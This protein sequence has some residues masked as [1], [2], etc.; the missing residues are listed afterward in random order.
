MRSMLC[1]N[2]CIQ[3]TLDFQSE[4]FCKTLFAMMCTREA[5]RL[6]EK[7][8]DFSPFNQFSCIEFKYLNNWKV[9]VLAASQRLAETTIFI[10][11]KSIC[12]H[13]VCT[14]L[15]PMQKSSIPLSI[16]QWRLSFRPPAYCLQQRSCE[17]TRHVMWPHPGQHLWVSSESAVPDKWVC[18]DEQLMEW[19]AKVMMLGEAPFCS[20]ISIWTNTTS[21]KCLI[22]SAKG[23]P[24]GTQIHHLV[25]ALPFLL[26]WVQKQ[27]VGSSSTGWKKEGI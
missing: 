24:G 17:M 9:L 6:S 21:C 18:G 23:H 13:A 27:L 20:L 12:Q 2:A 15:A 16:D 10:L 7:R 1:K 3:T 14:K 22:T 8:Y 5:V 26:A 25:Q 19:P 4:L 11:K